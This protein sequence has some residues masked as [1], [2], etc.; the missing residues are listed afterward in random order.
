[1]GTVY[2]GKAGNESRAAAV[3]ITSST[4]TTPAP[5]CA[6]CGPG[7]HRNGRNDFGER[8]AVYRRDSRRA[9]R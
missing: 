3:N 5:W 6:G 4:N 1:M 9:L 8:A 7:P 2:N